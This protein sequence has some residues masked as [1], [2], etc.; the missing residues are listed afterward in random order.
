MKN[1]DLVLE[2]ILTGEVFTNHS[3]EWDFSDVFPPFLSFFLSESETRQQSAAVLHATS[4]GWRLPCQEAQNR[5]CESSCVTLCCCCSLPTVSVITEKHAHI[6]PQLA[7]LI[8]QPSLLMD[9]LLF[10]PSDTSVTAPAPPPRSPE[11]LTDKQQRHIS[12]PMNNATV[13]ALWSDALNTK[14]HCEV[15]GPPGPPLSC[16]VGVHDV[17]DR[18]NYVACR[19]L[20]DKCSA[21]DV[22]RWFFRVAFNRSKSNFWSLLST[23]RQRQKN[24]NSQISIAVLRSHV[25][26]TLKG[27]ASL[28][29]PF[30]WS[31]GGLSR[32]D[33][34]REEGVW[35]LWDIS[36]EIWVTEPDKDASRDAIASSGCLRSS[37]GPAVPFV[38]VYFP[39][40]PS[41]P[42]AAS[43]SSFVPISSSALCPHTPFSSR[44]LPFPL[45]TFSSS[46]V[47]SSSSSFLRLFLWLDCSAISQTQEDSRSY[48]LSALCWNF[49][50]WHWNHRIRATTDTTRF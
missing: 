40:S 32:R 28:H 42:F 11:R 6:R 33:V 19:F 48:L 23:V 47:S 17:F 21:G 41:D 18:R 14:T 31:F 3:L 29:V 37:S 49:Y 22:C 35:S 30:K 46:L 13:T 15:S 44:L 4:C 5:Q 12:R 34:G 16:K 27:D 2:R 20:F 26:V 9:F 8:R 1:G 38:S 25:C 50:H 36:V 7:S 43:L 39:L 10:F 45:P 24:Q